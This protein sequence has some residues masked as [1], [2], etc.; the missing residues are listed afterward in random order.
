MIF[1]RITLSTGIL[2]KAPKTKF[3]LI[4]V[5]NLNRTASRA[6][7][8]QV[9]DWSTGSPVPLKVSPCGTKKCTV[10]VRPNK[11]VFL[12]ADV[13]KVTFKYEV[14]ITHQEDRKLITN[15]TGVTNTPFTPQVGD[16]VLQSNLVRIK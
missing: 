6:V 11:S 15:V 8:V 7:T 2:R 10:N 16:T 1:H 13:S 9:F 3:A 4:D 5:V 14:R 12:F